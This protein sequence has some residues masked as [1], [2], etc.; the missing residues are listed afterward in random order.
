MR[1]LILLITLAGCASTTAIAPRE[2][3]PA[4]VTLYRDTVTVEASDGA[5]CT[6]VRPAGAGGW[7]GVLA[8][9]PHPW[10]VAV[11]RPA[12]R[13]RVPLGPVAADPWVT[14]APPSG[15]LGYGPRSP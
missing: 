8:G 12:N 4:R 6:A 13:A 3:V 14:V 15:V 10:P 11:L 7:T 2:A 5:L 9:C 1:A